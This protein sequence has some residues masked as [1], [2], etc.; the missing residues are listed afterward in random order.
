MSYHEDR[1]L[2]NGRLP[3]YATVEMRLCNSKESGVS[4]CRAKY[5]RSE[6]SLVEV[7]WLLHSNKQLSAALPSNVFANTASR[8]R[9]ARAVTVARQS[10]NTM[11]SNSEVMWVFRCPTEGL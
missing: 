1:P 6:L 10:V 9:G 3:S 11:S 5:S 8:N 4:P 7:R 2:I